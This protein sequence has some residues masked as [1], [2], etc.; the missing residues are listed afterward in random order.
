MAT[1]SALLQTDVN[2]VMSVAIAPLL[3]DVES[4]SSTSV[5]HLPTD[6]FQVCQEQAFPTVLCL[7]FVQCKFEEK[8]I[9]LQSRNPK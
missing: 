4:L 1:D 5:V 2:F 7:Q 9:M 8:A 6:A 3:M